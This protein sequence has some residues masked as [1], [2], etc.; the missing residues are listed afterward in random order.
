V[1]LVKNAEA[2]VAA[3]AVAMF[4]IEL[5]ISP[6]WAYCIDIGH[7][8][9]GSISAAMNMAGS[10]GA[11]ASANAFPWLHRWTGDSGTYFRIAA[12]LNV[13]A[14]V[15]WFTMRSKSSE[16]VSISTDILVDPAPRT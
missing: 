10:F 16:K 8:N 2:A 11:L 13:L 4:G 6:S 12:G 5:T 9:S 7:K 15:C 3:F 1:P 14:I